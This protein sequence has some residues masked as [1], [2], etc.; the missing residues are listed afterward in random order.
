MRGGSPA[1]EGPLFYTHRVR[2]PEGSLH[3]G[4]SHDVKGGGVEGLS[5]IFGLSRLG[6]CSPWGTEGGWWV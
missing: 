3:G 1:R 5:R 4:L 6:Q 2:W